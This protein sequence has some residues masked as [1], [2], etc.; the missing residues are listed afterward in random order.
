MN[1]D[2]VLLGVLNTNKTQVQQNNNYMYHSDR[3][4]IPEHYQQHHCHP[5]NLPSEEVPKPPQHQQL[6]HLNPNQQN[7]IEGNYPNPLHIQVSH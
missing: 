7:D 1:C 3:L 4:H 6:P 5:I 2:K